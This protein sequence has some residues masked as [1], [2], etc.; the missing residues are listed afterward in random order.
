VTILVQ[1]AMTIL[2]V[3]QRGGD[4]GRGSGEGNGEGGSSDDNADE[5]GMNA[6][7][8]SQQA[9]LLLLLLLLHPTMDDNV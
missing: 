5:S 3:V 8:L 7:K 6:M 2:Q 1:E 9:L 4:R